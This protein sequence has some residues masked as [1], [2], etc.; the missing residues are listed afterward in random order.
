VNKEYLIEL[1]SDPRFEALLAEIL[2]NRPKVPA[3]TPDS[4]N[5]EIWKARSMERRGFDIWLA[6]LN[7][8]INHE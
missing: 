1:K 4:D 2:S 6:F 3:Y 7:L 8:E 5:T